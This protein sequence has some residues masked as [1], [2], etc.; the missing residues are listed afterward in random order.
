MRDSA[1]IPGVL[2]AIEEIWQAHPDWRLG[3]LLC[4]LAA[5]ADPTPDALWDIEDDVLVAEV[6]R[7]LAQ[8][9]Q[10]GAHTAG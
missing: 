3:Q 8:Q 10:P 4:N 2:Q 6:K 5:W 7:H 9:K 1:R